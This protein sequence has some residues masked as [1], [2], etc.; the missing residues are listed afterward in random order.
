MLNEL[1]F[2][3]AIN[4]DVL[5]YFLSKHNTKLVSETFVSQHHPSYSST[6]RNKN[7]LPACER[8]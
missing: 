1:Q 6:N 3:F 7:A 5:Q 2:P 4:G 8:K